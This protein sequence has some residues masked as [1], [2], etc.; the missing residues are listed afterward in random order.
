MM[1]KE[2]RITEIFGPTIQGE[3]RR[4]GTPCHFIRFAGCDYR[5]SWCDSPHAVLSKY[6]NETPKMTVDEIIAKINSLSQVKWIVLSGG[7]PAL[8]DL[9]VLMAYLTGNGFYTMMETQGTVFKEWINYIDDLCISP[10]PPSSRTMTNPAV[11]EKFLVQCRRGLVEP[12]LKIV[13]FDDGD[14]EYAKMMHRYFDNVEMYLSV[15]NEDPQLPTVSHPEVEGLNQNIY[16]TRD[17]VIEKMAWL[18]EKV[19]NDPEMRMVRVLP[20]MHVL[21]WGNQRGR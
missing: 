19:A 8:F 15:G 16:M 20:Q 9:Q 14:Y 12:Y 5:C 17:K 4:I 1:E 3:G 21:A 18:M 7:N 6:V 2:F 10:K 13:V 11:T